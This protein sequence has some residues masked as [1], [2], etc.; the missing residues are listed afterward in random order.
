[1]RTAIAIC[2]ALFCGV[3]HAQFQIGQRA[4]STS[5]GG[6]SCTT[7][8]GYAHYRVIT[9]PAQTSLSGDLSSYPLLISGTYSYLATVAN[10]GLVQNASGFDVAFYADSTCTSK[11]PWEVETWTASGLVNYWVQVPTISKTG[12]VTF[13]MAYDNAAITTDQSNKTGTWPSSFQAVYH[14]PDGTTLNV[15]DSTSHANNG[16]NSGSIATT[17]QVDGAAAFN[18]SAHITLN[19]NGN[20]V[21]QG[22]TWSTEAWVKS[23]SLA[24]SYNCVLC[25]TEDTTHVWAMMVKSSGKLALYTTN[26]FGNSI[27]YDGTGSHT[28][29][30]GTWY[31]VAFTYSNSAGLVGYVNGAS[32]G[33]ASAFNNLPAQV[34]QVVAAGY[35]PGI[36]GRTWNGTIDEVR[37]SNGALSADW[38]LTD[39]NSQSSPAAFYSVG[40]Q[41]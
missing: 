12:S 28:L 21:A 24:N 7:N 5:G 30:I 15:N 25:E 4:F 34:A 39:Y 10:G 22:I 27:H 6:G 18:G 9:V 20:L 32:D 16:A 40:A 1:M 11:L 17:G 38:I 29:S 33:T 37:V 14:V 41:N 31:L 35:H 36:T 8:S 13:V 23:T 26:A 3:G 19:S 2:L